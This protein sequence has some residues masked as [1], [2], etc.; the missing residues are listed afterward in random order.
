MFVQVKTILLHLF[1]LCAFFVVA[2]QNDARLWLYG[3]VEKKLSKNWE[4][5]LLIQNRLS[6]NMTRY[7]QLNINPELTYKLIK[8]IRLV[9]G[10]VQGFSKKNEGYFLPFR[11]MYGG[12][13]WR[14]HY[15]VFTFVYR[16]LFQMQT[17]AGYNRNKAN[18]WR[19]YDRNKLSLR[20]SLNRRITPYIAGE[21]NLCLIDPSRQTGDISRYRTF[22]GVNYQIN[23]RFEWDSYFLFQERVSGES[24]GN[25][26]YVFG[27]T[28]VYF[29]D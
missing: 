13:Q 21:F 28:L 25:R 18:V 23:R 27:L 1:I 8:P 20:Y 22:V 10:Y 26:Q 2:Q 6:E 7:T 12:I 29:L 4:G 5:S 19:F 16:H 3:K 15:K 17:T 11:Q 9:G 24:A 14:L